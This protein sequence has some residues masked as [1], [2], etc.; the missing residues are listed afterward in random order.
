MLERKLLH[1]LLVVE[2]VGGQLYLVA[3]YCQKETDTEELKAAR[4]E[5][6]GE[7]GDEVDTTAAAG[8][9]VAVVAEHESVEVEA[10]LRM[11]EVGI[12]VLVAGS[13]LGKDICS[14]EASAV[15]CQL[16]TKHRLQ[17]SS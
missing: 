10:Y 9:S 11:A 17:V 4:T 15:H 7:S 3:Q 6:G 14:A 16:Y 12:L 1:N 8:G 13:C 2:G 5:A